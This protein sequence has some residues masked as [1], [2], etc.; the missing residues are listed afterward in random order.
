MIFLRFKISKFN[1]IFRKWQIPLDSQ[2]EFKRMFGDI[3]DK[4][5]LRKR[6]DDSGIIDLRIDVDDFR[7]QIYATINNFDMVKSCIGCLF[8]TF[9]TIQDFR[10]EPLSRKWIFPITAKADLLKK[11][12]K[13]QHDEINYFKCDLSKLSR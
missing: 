8:D 6:N 12:E 1:R 4:N 5:V 3:L 13:L 9:K 11:L 7:Q 10:F 2:D